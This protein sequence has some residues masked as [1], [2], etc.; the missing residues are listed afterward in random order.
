MSSN[1]SLGFN[2]R[3][4]ENGIVKIPSHLDDYD[5]HIN[6][7]TYE[8]WE[9]R[10]LQLIKNNDFVAFGTHDCYGA[11]WIEYYDRLLAKLKR[12]GEFKTCDEISEEFFSFK[13]LITSTTF[14]IIKVN[15]VI[16]SNERSG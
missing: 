10:L 15:I 4:L 16:K 2:N 11:Y 5:L 1:H 9:K 13:I 12:F 14:F 7:I 6:K 8:E 3:R